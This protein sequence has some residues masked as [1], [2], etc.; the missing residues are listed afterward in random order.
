MAK[1]DV[2]GLVVNERKGWTPGV[3]AVFRL[4][5]DRFFDCLY[6]VEAGAHPGVRDSDNATG[7]APKTL[8][9]ARFFRLEREHLQRLSSSSK[10]MCNFY[11]I[12]PRPCGQW[13]PDG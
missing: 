13:L 6:R 9:F 11:D 8:Y 4:P 3:T 10:L 7:H 1:P 2:S 12:K 5:D